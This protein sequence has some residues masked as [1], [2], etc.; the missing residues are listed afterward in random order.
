MLTPEGLSARLTDA[1]LR[2]QRLLRT[3]A[4]RIEANG[5]HVRAEAFAGVLRVAG[6]I[7][8]EIAPKFLGYEAENWREDFFCIVTLTHFGRLLPADALLASRG[9]R[10]DLAT[11]AGRAVVEM[12]WANHRRPIRTYRTSTQLDY[13]LDG[14]T[15]PEDLILPSI[16]G[17]AV[18]GLTLAGINPFNATIQDA[19]RVLLREVRDGDTRKQLERVIQCLGKQLPDREVGR[20]RVLPSRARRWQALYDL[21][22]DILAGFGVRFGE[23]ESVAP[24]FL[25]DTWRAWQ[26]LVGMALR[27]ALPGTPVYSQR[28][29]QLGIREGITESRPAMVFPDFV[30]DS[31]VSTL[32]DA[33]YKGRFDDARYSVSE[34]DL[35]EALA[36]LEAAA[37]SQVVLLYPAIPSP[38]AAAAPGTCKQFERIVVGSR[39]VLGISVEVR[40]ISQENGL[41]EFA[42]NIGDWFRGN[43]AQQ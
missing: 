39:T 1:G 10:G 37:A 14:D 19:A 27:I 5:D 42:A 38:D 31:S 22:C 33:K 29:Y 41:A 17:F 21:S 7:E 16:D 18:S 11:L 4:A 35:Y 9:K 6:G 8:L 13:S 25:V 2:V 43:Q 34:A 23:N 30:L 28:E 26:D 40:G 3:K 36:F 24:G 15:D 32:V 12:F 20:R